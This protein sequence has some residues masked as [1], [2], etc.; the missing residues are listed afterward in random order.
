MPVKTLSFEHEGHSYEVR[1]EKDHKSYVCHVWEGDKQASSVPYTLSQGQVEAAEE[2]GD[3]EQVL[4]A[5]MVEVREA[6]TSGDLVI[7]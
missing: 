2:R 6:V 3:L 1:M 5:A 7:S 4:N